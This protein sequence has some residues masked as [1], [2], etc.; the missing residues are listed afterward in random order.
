MS[1]VGVSDKLA[2]YGVIT[3]KSKLTTELAGQGRILGGGQ[4]RPLTPC[5]PE[6]APV[7]GNGTPENTRASVVSSD[8]CL[9]LYFLPL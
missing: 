2:H 4:L 3:G 5:P 6:C 7:A 1:S 9:M 8:M